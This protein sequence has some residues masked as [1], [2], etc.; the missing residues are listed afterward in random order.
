MDEVLLKK[1][2]PASGENYYCKAVI[3]NLACNIIKDKSTLLFNQ[4]NDAFH[5]CNIFQ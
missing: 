1:N 2:V 3:K 4:F 5:V